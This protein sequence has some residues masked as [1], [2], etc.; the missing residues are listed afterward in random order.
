LESNWRSLPF[1]LCIDQW[2]YGMMARLVDF[3][4]EYVFQR[5]AVPWA[6]FIGRPK[7]WLLPELQW[8]LIYHPYIPGQNFPFGWR[9]FPD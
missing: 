2:G 8:E 3:P 9:V 7:D 1:D 4:G 5:S 6:Y